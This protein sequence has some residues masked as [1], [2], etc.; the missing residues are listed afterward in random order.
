MNIEGLSEATLEKFV[1]EGYITNF[2]DI[3]NLDINRDNI[4]KLDGF[5]EKS[6]NKL[7]DSICTSRNVTLDHFLVAL[8]IPGIGKSAAKT[9]CDYFKGSYRDFI[10][11]VNDGFDFTK[12]DDFGEVTAQNLAEY[13]SYCAPESLDYELEEELNFIIDPKYTETNVKKSADIEGKTFVFT[14]ALS[15]PRSF[16]EGIVNNNGGKCSGSVSKKTNYLVTDNPNS[17]SSKAVK[18]R[19]LGIP[20]LSEDDFMK[21]VEG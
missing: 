13:F 18:A 3:Y 10:Q 14:G 17:G 11:A 19:E 5:G 21:M 20:V 12:L 16:Y 6:W 15:R 1:E 8:S 9:I 4:I 2:R 7:W